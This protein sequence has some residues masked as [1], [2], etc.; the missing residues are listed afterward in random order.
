MTLFRS[1]FFF[2]IRILGIF[3]LV[4]VV[5][6]LGIKSSDDRHFGVVFRTLIK[7]GLIR[8]AGECRRTKG[9]AARGGALY[10]LVVAG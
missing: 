10:S 9:H 6:V 8:W 3:F 5:A 7:R 2:G 1:I 4:V